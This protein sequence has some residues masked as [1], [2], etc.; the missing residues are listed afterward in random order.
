MKVSKKIISSILI[1][2]LTLTSVTPAFAQ[3]TV[4]ENNSSPQIIMMNPNEIGSSVPEELA[5]MDRFL[6]KSIDGTIHLDVDSALAAGY[7]EAAVIGVANHLNG[8]NEHVLAGDMV[9]DNTFTAYSID[10][11]ES[12]NQI[13]SDISTFA[14]TQHPLYGF[15]GT[16]STWY[17]DTYIYFN[18]MESY[19]L[20]DA[21]QS[22]QNTCENIVVNLGQLASDPTW[23]ALDYANYQQRTLELITVG[24]GIVGLGAYLYKNQIITAMSPGYGIQWLIHNDFN[25]GTI[26]WAFSAQD[27]DAIDW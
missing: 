9:V 21:F 11:L 17:G 18:R 6:S 7:N 13:S 23:N 1:T 5:G 15:S 8:I 20:R 2:T 14:V 12:A 10:Y 27:W 24:V 25:S 22:T 4:E 16:V 3:I 19:C 26:G